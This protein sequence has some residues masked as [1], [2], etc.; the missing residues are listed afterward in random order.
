MNDRAEKRAA[1]GINS[2]AVFIA[3]VAFHLL[4]LFAFSGLFQ[5]TVATHFD[6]RGTVN[7][8]GDRY[9]FLFA[10]L[11][12]FAL[13]ITLILSAGML[14]LKYPR[15]TNI[16]NREYWL[17]PERRSETLE[18]VQSFV[19]W[20]GSLVTVMFGAILFQIWIANKRPTPQLDLWFVVVIAL[21][22]IVTIGMV[23][24]LYRRF[25]LPRDE[26]EQKSS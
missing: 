19:Y 10:W 24:A 17:A 20:F 6:L 18:Y 13:A 9:D 12:V 1:S 15:L 7:A 3:L 26:K 23:I 4:Q 11:A 14:C 5:P 16:P 25:S 2:R 21:D 22:W 8:F